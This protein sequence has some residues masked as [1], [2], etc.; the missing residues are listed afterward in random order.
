MRMTF[1]KYGSL[2]QEEKLTTMLMSAGPLL[3][4]TASSMLLRDQQSPA[5]GEPSSPVDV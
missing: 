1:L 2:S 5:Q 3:L 4:L